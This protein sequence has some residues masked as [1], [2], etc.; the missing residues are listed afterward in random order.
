MDTAILRM[1]RK[2]KNRETIALLEKHFITC[3]CTAYYYFFG[4]W[5]IAFN[6]TSGNSRILLMVAL[7][8][9]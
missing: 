5:P 1:S 2:Q 3:N 8:S 4:K 7:Q 6:F 9:N